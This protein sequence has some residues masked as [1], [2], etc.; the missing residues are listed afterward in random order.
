MTAAQPIDFEELL[1][2]EYEQ[3]A[4]R[5]SEAALPVLFSAADLYQNEPVALRPVLMD[6]TRSKG[7]MWDGCTLLFAK[8]KAGKSWL[9]LQVA[10]A[11]AG[12]PGIEGLSVATRGPVVYAALEEPQARTAKRMKMLANAGSW[13]ADL[14][15]IYDLLPLQGGG[16]EQLEAAIAKVKPRLLVIDTLTA[17]IKGGSKSS[18]DVFRSQYA[19]A[20]RVRKI[21][22]DHNLAVLLIHHSR[23]GG[24]SDGAVEAVA[25]T[26]GIAAAVDCLYYLKRK[27]ESE[28]TLEI[29]GRE[30]EES[31]WALRLG[32]SPFGWEFLG[33]DADHLLTGERK[34]L[35]ALLRED[36]A[37]APAAIALELGKTR[38]AV[39]QLLKRM[40]DDGQLQKDGNKYFP[41]LSKSHRVTEREK[42]GYSE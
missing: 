1:R 26:G 30:A 11:I 8:P 27:P 39:R 14:H 37:M 36:G 22:E 19:E 6:S 33:D 38:P 4:K 21:A 24:S 16:A 5:S 20:S 29:I 25:G 7:V 15:F 3:P 17:A 42:E 35:L 28:A 23:K 31:T 32:N 13:C 18:N 41:S 10:I 9:A 34:E 40:R 12:G 2:Q